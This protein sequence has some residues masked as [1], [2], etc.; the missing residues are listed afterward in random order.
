MHAICLA[1]F[2][3]AQLNGVAM[4]TTDVDPTTTSSKGL[5]SVPYA[6]FSNAVFHPAT[7]HPSWANE[8]FIVSGLREEDD[9][10]G[11]RTRRLPDTVTK[12]AIR[13]IL[14]DFASGA[15]L[16]DA[17]RQL[18]PAMAAK[19]V[20]T[21]DDIVGMTLHEKVC[22]EWQLKTVQLVDLPGIALDG[23]T[24]YSSSSSSSSGGGPD[25]VV[26][27]YPVGSATATLPVPVKGQLTVQFVQPDT[28]SWTA[29]QL[30]ALW[31]NITALEDASV[32]FLPNPTTKPQVQRLV[33][34]SL[35]RKQQ[36]RSRTTAPMP[37][38]DALLATIEEKTGE[39]R[40]TAA[41]LAN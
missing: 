32:L 29:V 26:R 19:A 39:L 13:Q 20:E 3:A 12:D 41:G 34:L 11:A 40:V 22:M 9:H 30:A 36:Q 5:L 18:K 6:V 23:M 7:M 31:T 16:R 21:V 28:E 27:V 33:T 24:P 2:D 37:R 14:S 1:G 25:L 8:C 35:L 38:L 15:E 17:M 10:P 4:T